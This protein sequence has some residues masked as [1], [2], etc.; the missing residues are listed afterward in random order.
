VANTCSGV[1]A[2]FSQAPVDQGIDGTTA[3]MPA[4]TAL[5]EMSPDPVEFTGACLPFM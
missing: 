1:T 2:I 5:E 3:F 4:A